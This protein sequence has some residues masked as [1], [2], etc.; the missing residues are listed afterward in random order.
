LLACHIEI[1]ERPSVPK[2]AKTTATIPFSNS[3]IAFS[4]P[5]FAGTTIAVPKKQKS[6]SAKSN[7]CLT[8]LLWRFVSSQTI[9]MDLCITFNA[10][11]QV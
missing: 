10:E 1:I 7:L 9:C 11:D 2:I 8:K 6:K 3:P 4:Q 5:A